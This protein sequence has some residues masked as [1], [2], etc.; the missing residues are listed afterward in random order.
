[1]GPRGSHP[2]ART[3][4]GDRFHQ[5]RSEPP[6]ERMPDLL[7]WMRRASQDE[8]QRILRRGT[9]SHDP[10]SRAPRR[11]G[12][13]RRDRSAA[14]GARRCRANLE[15]ASHDAAPL[16]GPRTE[17]AEAELPEG[18]PRRDRGR[19]R[20]TSR[21]TVGLSE[22]ADELLAVVFGMHTRHSGPSQLRRERAQYCGCAATEGDDHGDSQRRE[23][24]CS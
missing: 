24:R 2:S 12:A 8:P 7:P 17:P 3:C 5:Q 16:H 14:L 6:I 1:M 18:D 19:P 13:R 4:R 9:P 15:M 10:S 23:P 20:V 11:R 21:S 22:A